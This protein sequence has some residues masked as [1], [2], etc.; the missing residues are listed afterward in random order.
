MST[1][2][3]KISKERRIEMLNQASYNTG[4]LLLLLKKIG[5]KHW[6]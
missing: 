6:H 1:D 4:L 5:G 2:W 3:L